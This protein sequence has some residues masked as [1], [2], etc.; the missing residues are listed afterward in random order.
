MSS[1]LVGEP[2]LMSATRCVSKRPTWG[3]TSECLGNTHL[4]YRDGSGSSVLLGVAPCAPR[5]SGLKAREAVKVGVA[6]LLVAAVFLLLAALFERHESGWVQLTGAACL[7]MA[8]VL[9]A[10]KTG[11]SRDTE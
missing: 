8:A 5:T 11:R 7:V 2:Q 4:A 9:A 6:L 1:G 3:H 10:R